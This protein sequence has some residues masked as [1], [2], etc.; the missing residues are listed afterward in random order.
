MSIRQKHNPYGGIPSAGRTAHKLFVSPAAAF[1]R[2]FLWK[3][4]FLDGA[5]GFTIARMAALYA[6]RKYYKARNL[7]A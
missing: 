3:L 4:G 5:A 7:A 1:V 6:Y 2:S